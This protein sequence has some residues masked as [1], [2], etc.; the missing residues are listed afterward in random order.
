MQFSDW[1]RTIFFSGVALLLLFG[2]VAAAAPV[3]A[4]PNSARPVLMAPTRRKPTATKKPSRPSSPT[5]TPVPVA[6]ATNTPAPTATLPPTSTPTPTMTPTPTP[7]VFG[8]SESMHDFVLPTE[9]RIEIAFGQLNPGTQTL[10]R[11][12]LQAQYTLD[13]P[14]NFKILPTGSYIDLISS[15]FP[16][17]PDNPTTLAVEVNGRPISAIKLTK[18]NASL[19][20]THIELPANLLRSGSNLIVIRLTSGNICEDSGTILNVEIDEDALL[21]LGYQ[22]TSFKTDL[23]HYPLPFAE[24][25]LF[26]IPVTMVLPDQPTPEDLSAAMTLA[27]GLGRASR[28]DKERPHDIDLQSIPAKAFDPE[29]HSTHHLIAIGLPNANTL[30]EKIES[31]PITTTLAIQSAD[32]EPQ[33]G[34]LEVVVSPWNEYRLLLIVSGADHEGMLKASHILNR[35]ERFP[36]IRGAQ[37]TI[38]NFTP[39]PVEQG[40]APSQTMT[41]HSLDRQDETAYGARVAQYRYDFTLP[42]GWQL[43]GPPVFTLRFSH[44]NILDP[45]QS[46]IDA[47]L[48]GQPIGS[49]FLDSTNATEGEW[50]IPLPQRTLQSGNNQL[51]IGI[52]MILPDTDEVGRCRLLDDKRLWTVLS[53][54]S[55]ISVPYA[56]VD[57]RPNLG[58]LLYPY[59]QKSGLGQS[60]FVLPDQPDVTL[61]NDLLQLGVQLGTLADVDYLPTHITYASETDQD[62]WQ[63]FHLVLIGR[64]TENS[65]LRELNTHLPRPFA[66][67]QEFTEQGSKDSDI[68][69]PI[70]SEDS[71][72]PASAAF[73]LDPKRDTGVLQTVLSPWNKEK[74]L[75][76]VAGT[77]DKGVHLAI[78]AML[79]PIRNMEGN[80]A[81]VDLV[82]GNT[83]Q[84]SAYATDTR[85][86][87]STIDNGSQE[88]HPAKDTTPDPEMILLAQRWWR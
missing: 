21:S 40:K 12:N 29:I 26:R 7:I 48:N 34:F 32:I 51:Q 55:E 64:A 13:I 88:G 35:E 31:A 52:E 10:T 58:Y 71:Q 68:L 86:A 53:S 56:I 9:G 46:V 87:N 85:P 18:D 41:L 80:I 6:T 1:K 4:G 37:A 75:L 70:A 62:S 54:E 79:E 23:S 77:T 74:A 69:A 28:A 22:Q 17:D 76:A 3:E 50:A 67:G 43:T 72:Q 36:P 14:G 39:P 57:S 82:S 60:V 83:D 24:K 30:L 66:V 84:I 63:D 59:G 45:L 78:R 61:V 38:T 73:E 11:D 27:A 16:P 2:I 81:I 44:S 42:P 15:H 8:D 47:S 65:L 33:Q 19:G 20:Q 49:A 5:N 25:S